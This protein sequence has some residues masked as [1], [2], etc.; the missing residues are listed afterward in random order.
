MEARR[1]KVGGLR[2]IQPITTLGRGFMS[3]GEN[4]GR[5]T[6]VVQGSGVGQGDV[7]VDPV[8]SIGWLLNSISTTLHN[9][10]R[11]IITL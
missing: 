5:S 2:G 11:L 4:S 8:T 7:A 10:S 1:R 3:Y 9:A 6:P